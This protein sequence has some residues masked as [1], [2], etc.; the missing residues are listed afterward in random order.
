M[1]TDVTA[2][3]GDHGFKIVSLTPSVSLRVD[4]KLDEG[5]DCASYYRGAQEGFLDV[6]MLL[7][8]ML[9]VCV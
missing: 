8:F 5:E 7:I 9:L 1:P 2:V 3:A 6:F 4:V